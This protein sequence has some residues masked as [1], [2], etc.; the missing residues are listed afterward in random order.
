M[1]GQYPY[2]RYE[3]ADKLQGKQFLEHGWD[4][5]SH[6]HSNVLH[7]PRCNQ[8][9]R[10]DDKRIVNRHSL[11]SEEEEGVLIEQECKAQVSVRAA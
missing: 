2:H 6:N 8:D 5:V 10:E 4:G 1:G 3:T 7:G 9:L 11:S